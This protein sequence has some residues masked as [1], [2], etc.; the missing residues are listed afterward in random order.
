MLQEKKDDDER[1]MG[2]G[3]EREG[4]TGG[5]REEEKRDRGGARRKRK[6]KGY[7][8]SNNLPAL[9]C[10]LSNIIDPIYY[11]TMT[12]EKKI[13]AKKMGLPVH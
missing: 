9:T 1:D 8:L 13:K 4:S 11:S 3:E 5:G 12:E 10:L 2:K 6:G 7:S